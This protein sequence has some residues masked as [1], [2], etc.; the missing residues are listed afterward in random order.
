MQSVLTACQQVKDGGDESDGSDSDPCD[1]THSQTLLGCIIQQILSSQV[2]LN[3]SPPFSSQDWILLRFLLI[4]YLCTLRCRLCWHM[5]LPQRSSHWLCCQPCWQTLLPPHAYIY[6]TAVCD[7][8]ADTTASSLVADTVL[9]PIGYVY[10]ECGL[11]GRSIYRRA[12]GALGE[13]AARETCG[14]LRRR[15]RGQHTR[16][17]VAIRSTVCRGQLRRRIGGITATSIFLKWRSGVLVYLCEP[18]C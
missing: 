14:R 18:S 17:G 7:V 13:D 16:R 11:T 1:V 4:H 5:L 10:A 9:L 8:L 15:T 3:Q 2:T 6:C 12:G